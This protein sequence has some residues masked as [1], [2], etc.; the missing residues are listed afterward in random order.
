[1]K[2]SSGQ[3]VGKIVRDTL[4][5]Q[6]LVKRTS[7]DAV[8][9]AVDTP[10]SCDAIREAYASAREAF[11]DSRLIV[12]APSKVV[13]DPNV[14]WEKL[15]GFAPDRLIHSPYT[16]ETLIEAM[17]GLDSLPPRAPAQEST[18]EQSPAAPPLVGAIPD[19][20][21]TETLS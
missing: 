5:L 8:F 21:V 9:F 2:Q 10:Q 19:A 4:T 1:M 6:L 13:D 16:Y 11:G 14:P 15:L 20:S 17:Q 7:P 18:P 12:L 3:F